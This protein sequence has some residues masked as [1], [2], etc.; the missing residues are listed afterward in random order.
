MS[1]NGVFV[2]LMASLAGF[3]PCSACNY[4]QLSDALNMSSENMTVRP[5]KDWKK[6]TTV[7]VNIILYTVVKLDTATQ[8]L[9]TF[10]WFT[11]EW[12][13]E[14]ISWNPENYCGIQS[15]FGSFDIWQPDIYI[16]EMTEADNKNPVILYHNISYNG[17]IKDSKPL[18][19]VSTCNLIIFMYPFDIQHCDLSFTTFSETSESVKIVWKHDSRKVYDL[20]RSS[21]FS[22]GEW[23]LLNISVV[24][25]NNMVKYT[26][27]LKRSPTVQIIA[28]IIPICFLVILDVA[29]MFIS[30]TE[31][32]RIMFKVVVV[33]GFF[34]LIVVLNQI[35]PTTD[36]PPLLCLFCFTCMALMVVSLMGCI[37]T[38]YLLNLSETSTQTPPW[39]KFWI[40]TCLAR[41]LFFNINCSK[42]DH[43]S[44][45]HGV[46]ENG[47]INPRYAHKREDASPVTVD[48]NNI[49]ETQLLEMLLLEVQTIQQELISHKTEEDGESD[50]YIIAMVLNRLFIIL[51]LLSIII[52]FIVVF[53]LWGS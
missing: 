19:I 10:L 30:F 7:Q 50:W 39:M 16:Y 43:I 3:C 45:S 29:G 14:F 35:L 36:S 38:S 40:K 9:T 26:I 13:N 47:A 23:N 44:N 15:F 27:S 8:T 11:L 12:E 6:N 42:R 2:L 32:N 51:Y 31:G 1:L 20:S 18:R 46:I 34:V 24:Q 22:I 17:T 48:I 33:L 5:V 25:A 21:F 49:T 37:A 52:T 4:M 41:F 28:F 53:S